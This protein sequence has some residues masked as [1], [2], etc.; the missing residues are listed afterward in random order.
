MVT[1]TGWRLKQLMI[2]ALVSLLPQAA[3]AT[4]IEMFF[5]GLDLEYDDSATGGDIVTKGGIDDLVSLDVVVDSALVASID[6]STAEL[7]LEDL[8]QKIPAAGGEVSGISGGFDLAADGGSLALSFD[9]ATVIWAAI[10]DVKVV[11]SEGTSADWT[12][13]GG[14][15]DEYPFLPG[16]TISLSFSEQVGGYMDDGTYVTMFD[17]SGTGEVSGQLVP[18]PATAVLLGMG[19]AGLGLAGRRRAARG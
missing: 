13:S 2:V 1:V 5:T 19:I 16:S 4:S 8:T 10:G 15:F 18:E 3:S 9:D 17:S 12:A 7:L 11:F 6:G 14:V